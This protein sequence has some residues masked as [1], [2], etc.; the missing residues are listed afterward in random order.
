MVTRITLSLAMLIASAS[1]TFA[2]SDQDP[3]VGTWVCIHTN[4]TKEVIKVSKSGNNYLLK[5]K[6]IWTDGRNQYDNVTVTSSSPSQID[7]YIF[8]KEWDNEKGYW[9]HY[10]WYCIFTFE[11]GRASNRHVRYEYKSVYC[12]KTIDEGTINW[13]YEPVYYDKDDPDW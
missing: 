6:T 11:N 2:Q 13:N 1:M 9:N 10:W 7:Y 4:G 3:L 5:K 8:E 12:D